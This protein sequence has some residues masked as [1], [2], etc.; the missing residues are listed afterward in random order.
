MLTQEGKLYVPSVPIDY[1]KP[2]DSI[3]SKY[4]DDKWHLNYARWVVYN[5]YNPVNPAIVQSPYYQTAGMNDEMVLNMMYYYGVQSSEYFGYE[6]QSSTGASFKIPFVP[7]QAARTYIEHMMG[8]GRTMI[9]PIEDA[10]SIKAI[11]TRSI[12]IKKEKKERLEAKF[13]FDSFRDDGSPVEYVPDGVAKISSEEELKKLIEDIK[14]EIEIKGLTVARGIYYEEKLKQKYEYGLLQQLVC[15]LTSIFA[16]VKGGKLNTYIPPA[17]NTIF[18]P[19][20]IGD[21]GDDDRFGGFIKRMTPADIFTLYPDVFK[22]KDQRGWVEQMAQCRQQEILDYWNGV[23]GGMKPNFLWWDNTDG[24]CAVAT[25]YFLTYDNSRYNVINN[26]KA[27][28]RI[29]PNKEYHTQA[30]GQGAMKGEDIEGDDWNYKWHKATLIGN[31]IITNWGVCDYQIPSGTKYKRPVPPFTRYSNR[32]NMGYF[33]SVMGR[34]RPLIDYKE[35][36][37]RK[38]KDLMDKDMNKVYILR[39]SALAQMASK[40]MAETKIYEDFKTLGFSIIDDSGQPNNQGDN[41]RTVTE[42]IDFSTSPQI[43]NYMQIESR[44][45]QE[46]ANIANLPPPVLGTQNKIIGKGVLENTIAQSQYS[47]MGLYKGYET[48][49]TK[50]MR[51]FLNMAKMADADYGVEKSYQIS[52]TQSE[53]VQFN[54]DEK[55]ELLG[56]YFEPIDE[57]EAENKEVFRQSIH[58]FMQN[59]SLDTGEA[60]YASLKLLNSKSYTQGMQSLES[61]NTKK[62][63]EMMAAQNATVQQE[64]VQQ[65]QLIQQETLRDII[66]IILKEE[67]ANYREEIKVAQDGINNDEKMLME[68]QKINNQQYKQ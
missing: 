41:K 2:Y 28:R 21:Y 8:N 68:R 46:M 36:V 5:G 62:R 38:I 31:G 42:Q 27:V 64:T 23:A 44:I 24:T 30:Y 40:D 48:F 51:L 11:D 67:N 29:D 54:K 22:D 19:Q 4:K 20:A 7:D 17:Y 56:F 53:L 9:E 58:A 10:M 26:G 13:L 25:V 47:Q 34:F 1:S 55:Y 14:L 16:E 49:I 45:E 57:L 37:R 60:L 15:N 59:A 43:I 66:K 35:S 52:E 65:Q 3:L 61:Y 18:D 32:F 50:S 39:S 6:A 33:K 12:K 63:A